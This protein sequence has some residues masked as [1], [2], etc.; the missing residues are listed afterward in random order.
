MTLVYGERK[1]KYLICEWR[2][3]FFGRKTKCPSTAKKTKARAVDNAEAEASQEQTS[4][5]HLYLVAD[6]GAIALLLRLLAAAA[7]AATGCSTGVRGTFLLLPR[8]VS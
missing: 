8:L 5:T 3:I 7:A 4:S 1:T 2:F 6:A